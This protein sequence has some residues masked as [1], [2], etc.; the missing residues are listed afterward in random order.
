MFLL[1][2]FSHSS[3]LLFL[4][5]VETPHMKRLYGNSLRTKAGF[6]QGV[7]AILDEEKAALKKKVVEVVEKAEKVVEEVKRTVGDKI[8]PKR[9]SF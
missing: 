8:G 5:Y 6:E 4:T 3:H 1:A 9:H 7:K 2:L